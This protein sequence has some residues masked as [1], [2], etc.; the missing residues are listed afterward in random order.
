L[1]RRGDGPDRARHKS[2]PAF[3]FRA[4]DFESLAPEP[5]TFL[6]DT[7]KGSYADLLYTVRYRNREAL[8]FERKSRPH[9]FTLLQLL[10]YMI[11]IWDKPATRPFE[12]VRWAPRPPS[13]C[14]SSEMGVE[15]A[16]SLFE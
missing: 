11:R 1:C 6:D 16:E 2:H 3:T 15:E 12:P 4:T 7:L 8:L 14:F 10:R 9:R 13:A 5:D